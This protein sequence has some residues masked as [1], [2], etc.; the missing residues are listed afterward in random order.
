MTWP[1]NGLLGPGVCPKPGALHLRGEY[2]QWRNPEYGFVQDTRKIVFVK[3]LLE[4]LKP[5]EVGGLAPLHVHVIHP[6][7]PW[8]LA[9]VVNQVLQTGL[10]A[11][12]YNLHP[13]IRQVLGVARQTQ[14]KGFFA[15]E[16]TITHPLNP[17]TDQHRNS[18]HAFNLQRANRM[19]KRASFWT[20]TK[21][22]S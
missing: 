8:A 9:Q 5:F 16:I 18:L 12:G 20:G 15:G 11:L 7:T 14:L 13:P 2:S 6:G 4:G 19:L 3:S 1:E 10:F 17:P 22:S 21:I